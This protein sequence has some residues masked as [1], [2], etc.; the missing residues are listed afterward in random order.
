MELPSGRVAVFD[1]RNARIS[2]LEA[3]GT[4]IDSGRFPHRVFGPVP[5]SDS[6]LLAN[7]FLRSKTATRPLGNSTIGIGSRYSPGPSPSLRIVNSNSPSEV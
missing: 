3:D 6:V 1:R 7:A 2:I 5:V 4:F